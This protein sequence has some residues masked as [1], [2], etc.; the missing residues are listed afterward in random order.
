MAYIV[1]AYIVMAYI[2]M[3]YIVMAYILMAYILM[4][5]ILMAYILMAYVNQAQQQTTA[6]SSVQLAVASYGQSME[7]RG[8]FV[9]FCFVWLATLG[10]P[11]VAVR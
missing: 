1:M 7:G 9:L 10:V 2:V 11:V 4:A 5:Y 3:A 8:S 6:C